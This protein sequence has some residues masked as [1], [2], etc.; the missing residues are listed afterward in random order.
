MDK[1][2]RTIA[3]IAKYNKEAGAINN[4]KTVEAAMKQ[5]QKDIVKLEKSTISPELNKQ[6]MAEAA[7]FEALG[8]SVHHA[9]DEFE[10]RWNQ[11]V[12]PEATRQAKAAAMATSTLKEVFAQFGIHF[13]AA[14]VIK[15]FLDVIRDSFEF[16]KSLDSAL[17]QIYVVSSLSINRV[18]EL[19]QSFINMAK[20][21]G[22]ALDDVTRAAVLFYQQGL[23]TDEV[24]EMT[25]VTAQFA[26]VAGIDATDAADKL[27]AAVNGYR[28]SAQDALSVADKFNKVAAAS[29]ADINELSTAFSKAAAQANQAGVSMDNYLAY[30][31]TMEEATREAPENLGTSLKTIFSRMQQIKTGENTEEGTDVNAVETALRSVNIAL[32]DTNGQ[33]RD[34]EEIFAELGPKW[35]TLDRN[36]QAYLGTI[37]AGTRQ[38]SRFITLMQNWDRVLDLANQSA[39]SAGQQSLMHAKAMDSIV[40]KL[41]QL[42][43]A[44]QEFVSNIGNSSLFKGLISGLTSLLKLFNS[45]NKPIIALSMAVSLFS[46]KLKDL[47]GPLIKMLTN[48]KDKIK[49]GEGLSSILYGNA[50]EANAKDVEIEK[51][52]QILNQLRNR[53]DL[54]KEGNE[55]RDETNGKILT[56][57]QLTED[58]KLKEQEIN[59]LIEER[60]RLLQKQQAQRGFALSKIG[61]AVQTFGLMSG[62]TNTAG[63]LSATGGGI[64]AA[65]RFMTGDVIGGTVDAVTSLIT[66]GKTIAD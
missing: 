18:N 1:I 9:A 61:T 14:A 31:A 32:R 11:E 46:T 66:L 20:E 56:E 34:L 2:E 39:N 28:L 65:G 13:T 62:D 12:L 26:K 29:A 48:V 10:P 63:L 51:N 37:I 19:Q 45:G 53:L 58:I 23:N 57:E 41:Q 25:R 43:V 8:A 60:D 47:N 40:S 49:N 3:S 30:I 64:R 5:V 38:Q 21:T 24:L 52:N 50:Q 16:Y 17:N 33:L 22:M 7:S 4:T 59:K 6:N 55:I 44:W 36:T 42:N 54:V 27:T 15:K 35:N